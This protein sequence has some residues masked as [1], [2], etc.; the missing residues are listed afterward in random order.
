MFLEVA[1]G[2]MNNQ[3]GGIAGLPDFAAGL[4][5]LGQMTSQAPSQQLQMTPQIQQTLPNQI[6]PQ[7]PA[8]LQP[9]LPPFQQQMPPPLQNQIPPLQTQLPTQLQSQ[10][11]QLL[12]SQIPTQLMHKEEDHSAAL[13]T[14]IQGNTF[15]INQVPITSLIMF[16]HLESISFFCLC[17]NNVFF[18]PKVWQASVT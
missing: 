8:Q 1:S 11:P 3:F 6:Q 2:M 9:Q 12:Q 18:L 4:R 7:I 13:V 17:L 16:S 15:G 10:I 14:G 5:A